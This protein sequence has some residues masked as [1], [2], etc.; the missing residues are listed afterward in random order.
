MVHWL[1]A[2]LVI[3]GPK[4]V[5]WNPRKVNLEIIYL[6]LLSNV[7]NG[8]DSIPL[9]TNFLAAELAEYYEGRNSFEPDFEMWVSS[10]PVGL[11]EPLSLA[12]FYLGG[13]LP[14][15]FPD[16]LPVRDGQLGFT[17]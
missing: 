17:S 8:E 1:A 14:L 6:K 15:P 16:G 12:T 11:M 7:S 9:L 13:L 4:R 10:Q 5:I 3:R 2:G